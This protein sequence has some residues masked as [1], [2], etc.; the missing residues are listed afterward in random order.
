MLPN[1]ASS[2]LLTILEWA[3]WI[4]SGGYV[5]ATIGV[6]LGVYWEGEHFPQ[7]TQ[8]RG[9]RLLLLSLALDTFFTLSIF[10]ADG[11]ISQ[12]QRREI[13]ALQIQAAPRVLTSEQI[14]NIVAALKPFGSQTY[15]LSIPPT[16]EPG[17]GLV[18]QLIGT[19]RQAGWTL[20]SFKGPG[21][22]TVLSPLVAISTL[23]LS[24]A[25][26]NKE[27]QVTVPQILVGV[28]VGVVGVVIAFE[29]H[30]ISPVTGALWKALDDAHI[31]ATEAY[32]VV[33]GCSTFSV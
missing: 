33:P 9:W 14:S 30:N 6:L 28:N 8:Q 15:D 4:S 23:D 32:P 21:P 29:R 17:S 2:T 22:T 12:L 27:I 1:P 13:V 5:L 11:W 20:Q 19:L 3:K 25:P 16:L 7:Q 24:A 18:S 10:A 26:P 31:A